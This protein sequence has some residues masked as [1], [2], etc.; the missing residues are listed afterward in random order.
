MLTTNILLMVIGLVI[1]GIGGELLVRGAARLAR[2]LGLSPL[3]VGLTIIAFGTSAPEI[4]VTMQSA[5]Q[6]EDDLAIAN[7]VGSCIMNILVVL[8]VAALARPLRVSRNVIRT[9]APAMLFF[10]ALFM[11]FAV[12]NQTI[13]RWEGVL[14]VAALAVYVLFTYAESR[15]QPPAI[16]DE[17]EQDPRQSGKS[18]IANSVMVLIGI[19]ALV[20]GA[21]LIVAGAV[22]V[23]EMIGVSTRIIGL[24][25][26]ALGTSLPELATCVVA[27]RRG[28]PD[29]AIGNIIGSNVFNILA[30]IGITSATFPLDVSRETLFF[31]APV[32]LAAAVIVIPILR[33]GRM[34]SRREGVLLLGLYGAYLVLVLR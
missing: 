18:R 19:V 10:T 6:G 21:D 28:Q 26:V 16:E 25:I 29:I 7:V 11:L 14:F 30:V 27:A 8:G 22:G 4:A 32:M 23:A 5:Y 13:D 17:Y 34:I 20:K 1:L 9:D 15:R 33:T 2:Q 3:V 12:D 31:D 24:T